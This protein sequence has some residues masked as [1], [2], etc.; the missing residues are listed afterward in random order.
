MSQVFISYASEDRATARALAQ[1]FEQRG[2]SV[3]WDRHIP[4][5]KSFDRVI[6]DAI[7]A[8]S[9][10]VVLWSS[11]SIESDWVKAE[12]DE[13]LQRRILVPAMIEEVRMPL[14]FRRIHAADLT[15]WQAG[16]SSAASDDLIRAV[17]HM[18]GLDDDK[19]AP[20]SRPVET[21]VEAEGQGSGQDPGAQQAW[22]SEL[23]SR[24]WYRRKIRV[25]LPDS[26]HV[27]DV[28]SPLGKPNRVEL[29]GELVAQN[30]QVALLGWEGRLEFDVADGNTRRAAVLELG[31]HWMTDKITKCRL[32]IDDHLLYAETDGWGL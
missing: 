31:H 6:E 1:L 27:I 17:G 15:G 12:A 26:V 25:F 32:T 16:E 5:G 19:T 14:G 10:V 23:L 2:W 4:P 3:W 29:D 21:P 20:P 30:D 22:Q 7:A 13:G 24:E 11:S 8:A 28:S 9:C 18:L